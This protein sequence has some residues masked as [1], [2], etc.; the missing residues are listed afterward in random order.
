MDRRTPV[1]E[2]MSLVVFTVLSVEYVHVNE[3]LYIKD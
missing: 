3:V 1:R 2:Y